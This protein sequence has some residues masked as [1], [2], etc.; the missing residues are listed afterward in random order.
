V[1]KARHLAYGVDLREVAI[2]IGKR[3][4]S[5]VEARRI[6]GDALVVARL[7]D[8]ASDRALREHFVTIHDV[9]HCEE[10]TLL[11][12]HPYVV[13]ELIRGG[14]IA[15]CLQAGPFPLKRTREYFDQV[16]KAMAYMHSK[17]IAHRDL[18]PGNLLVSRVDGAPDVVKVS[19][20]GLAVEV[21]SLLGW[22]ASGGDLAYLAPES[23]SHDICSPQS[24]V[25]MLGL[26]FLEMLTG[27]N[28]FAGLGQHLRG[29]NREHH[30][31]LR[32]IHLLA[33]QAEKFA[34]LEKHP[35]IR[36]QPA[37]GRVIRQALT[38]DMSSRPYRNA[39]DL[40]SDWLA[41]QG[42]PAPN[43]NVPAW[44][45]VR[46]L[47]GEAEQCFQVGEDSKG[48]QL[49]R[50]A[51]DLNRDVRQ[52]PDPMAVGRTYLLTVQRLL[53]Q[54]LVDQ[55]GE[56]AFEGYRR[57]KCRSTLSAMAAYYRSLR[58]PVAENYEQQKNQCVDHS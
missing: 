5:D 46:S 37:L 51:I 25:Y 30:K 44:D 45:T 52:V 2:K 15:H 10:G 16:L 56:V 32:R 24:D 17:P 3:P 58:S 13:M 14:S 9:G 47:T 50:R 53:E 42:A 11:A 40:Q 39:I 4:M 26:V 7:V 34:M 19:D 33:R 38:T 29:E 49:L 48:D 18:K 55:A 21:D 36:R 12:G 57:R 22:V 31:E 43:T 28:P 54:G 41:A 20:F 35:E 27:S 8:E 6:F 1:Y 23:F